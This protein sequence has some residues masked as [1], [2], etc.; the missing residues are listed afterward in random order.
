MNSTKMKL[1]YAKGLNFECARCGDCCRGEPGFVWLRSADTRRIAEHLGIS[2][3]DFLVK[4]ART[5]SKRISLRELP[6][7]DCIFWE[8]K[9]LIYEARPPQC[10]SFPFWYDNTG[11][12]K[13]WQ[14]LARQCPGANSGAR[15]PVWRMGTEGAFG[16][17]ED[18]YSDLASRV[19]E[20]GF[21]CKSCGKCCN[22]ARSGHELFTTRLEAYY[23]LDK[24]GMPGG[25][26]THDVC[27]YLEGNACSVHAHRTLGCRLFFCGNGAGDF[28]GLLYEKYR[29]A[30]GKISSA[31]LLPTG[32]QRMSDILLE[33][34][35]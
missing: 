10:R 3:K 34:E 23:L 21:A 28:Y 30:I 4:Y 17:I 29:T 20:A 22:F 14:E 8:K 9:C 6:N 33:V 2:E 24:A 25:P 18:L 16:E 13:D 35:T 1:W 32:Y 7:G 19:S 11:S 26:I 27:P 5:F 12:Q 31:Y 15:L